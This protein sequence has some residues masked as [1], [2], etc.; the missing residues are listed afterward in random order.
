MTENN[1]KKTEDCKHQWAPL[2]AKAGKKTLPS[3]VNVCL[4]CGELK[5]GQRT[6]RMSRYRL[7]MG[8]LPI[9]NTSTRWGRSNLEWALDKLLKGAGAGVNPIEIDV[10]AET[11][12]SILEKL[13]KHLG[14]WW[15]NNNWLPIGMIANGRSGTGNFVWST[16][17]IESDTGATSD[18]STQLFKE[19]LGLSGACS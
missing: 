11:G 3:L 15:F 13:Q 6:I 14:V 1:K 16:S 5:V 9:K 18:S 7:D 4:R 17:Y 19:A 12:N 8:G 2:M 10:P